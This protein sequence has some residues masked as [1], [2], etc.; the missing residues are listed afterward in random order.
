MGHGLEC[1]SGQYWRCVGAVPERYF[2]GLGDLAPDS[3]REL[4]SRVGDELTDPVAVRRSE[5]I[6]SE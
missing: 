1:L 5:K 2:P 3:R 4:C 6:V